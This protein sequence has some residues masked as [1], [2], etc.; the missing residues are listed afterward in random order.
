MNNAIA[1]NVFQMSSVNGFQSPLKQSW[2]VFFE[3]LE[4]EVKSSA[5]T[6]FLSGSSCSSHLWLE[7]QQTHI[8]LKQKQSGSLQQELDDQNLC[9]TFA[10]NDGHPLLYITGEPQL[11]Q[12]S[13]ILF[14]PRYNSRL[15]PRFSNARFA[16]GSGQDRSLWLI[17]DRRHFR[18]SKIWNLSQLKH[19]T[20]TLDSDRLQQ[21]FAR[22]RDLSEAAT[23]H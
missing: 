17:Q 15:Y 14:P 8:H 20:P 18:V 1:T 11:F 9:K 12:Y 16:I 19:R 2:S 23:V 7:K 5:P 6:T 3:A 13:I 21:A 22:V 10:K 4:V